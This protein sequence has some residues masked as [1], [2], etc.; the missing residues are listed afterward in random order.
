M[1]HVVQQGFDDRLTRI[2]T[3]VIFIVNGHVRYVMIIVKVRDHV[4]DH[5][6]PIKVQEKF[7]MARYGLQV[8]CI[9]GTPVGVIAMRNDIVPKE[10]IAIQIVIGWMRWYLAA[11]FVL[12]PPIESG[13]IVGWKEFGALMIHGI[14]RPQ[15]LVP[16]I[17]H[18][19]QNVGK[20]IPNQ[21]NDPRQVFGW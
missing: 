1:Q 15:P 19:T 6:V 14:G 17:I 21:M 18:A 4:V 12:A 7:K 3:M 16:L 11:I 9:K 10:C 5:I 8:F 13:A 20:G 2:R